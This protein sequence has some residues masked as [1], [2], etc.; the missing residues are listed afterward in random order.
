MRRSFG[1]E[2][3]SGISNNKLNRGWLT[4][5]STEM[6]EGIKVDQ[7]RYWSNVHT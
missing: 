6:L 3:T 5:P 1:T 7:E 2:I 4:S